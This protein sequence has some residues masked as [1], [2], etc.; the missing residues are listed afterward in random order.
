MKWNS[1]VKLKRKVKNYPFLL[2]LEYLIFKYLL[3]GCDVLMFQ[4][5]QIADNLTT[6]KSL[7]LNVPQI[8][9]NLLC[10]ISENISNESFKCLENVG[11]LLCV[12]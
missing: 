3:F 11:S 7:Q 1:G 5:K 8:F 9:W 12:N 10:P 4:N 2:K 6:L